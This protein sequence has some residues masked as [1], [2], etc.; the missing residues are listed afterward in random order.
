MSTGTLPLKSADARVV[1]NMPFEEYAAAEGLNG[2]S[3]VNLRRSP[4]YFKYVRENP[5]PATEALILGTYTHRLILEPHRRGDFAVWM[6]DYGRRY[7][8]K[9]DAFL[10]ENAGASIVTESQGDAMV[11]MAVAARGHLPIL[12]YANAPGPTE[13]SL[14]WTDSVSGR[15]FKCRLDKW[16]P[17]KKT[18]FDLKTARSCEKY[19]F[20]SQAYTLGY[21]I[22]MAVQWMG[23]WAC[24]GVDADLKLGVVESKQPHESAVYRVPLDVRLQALEE[25]DALVKK[26]TECERLNVWPA[27]E[28]DET[29]L[30]L[31]NWA[32]AE[33][34]TDFQLEM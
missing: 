9:W 19:K 34:D 10:E 25:L 27:A 12:K 16:I 2:S 32:T 33:S 22:K 29:D 8:K 26:L 21:H 6:G 14:F 23:V 31:P 4:M 28:T 7:G 24:F 18:V 3:I 30:V 11:G 20:G 13:L 17:S 5:Q 1:E 15:K